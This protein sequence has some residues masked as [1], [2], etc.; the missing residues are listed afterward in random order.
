MSKLRVTILTE[1]QPPRYHY[2]PDEEDIQFT[3]KF[4]LN[5]RENSTVRIDVGNKTKSRLILN[6]Y[7]LERTIFIIDE[8]TES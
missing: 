3:T 4:F 1:G 6:S 8:L 7:Q 2:P 5:I